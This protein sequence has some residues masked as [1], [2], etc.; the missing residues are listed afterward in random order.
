MKLNKKSVWTFGDLLWFGLF[1]LPMTA[2]IFMLL[3]IVPERTLATRVQTFDLEYS[4]YKERILNKIYFKG[5]NGRIYYGFFDPKYFVENILKDFDNKSA[6]KIAV[7]VSIEN[8][9]TTPILDSEDFK[10]EIKR[11]LAP[12]RY[13]LKISEMPIISTDKKIYNLKIQQVFPK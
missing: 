10:Y 9:K 4:I 13:N 11:P 3:L 5:I 2:I 7:N 1:Y 8:L 6:K 12:I